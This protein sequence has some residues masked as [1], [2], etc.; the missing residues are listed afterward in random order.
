LRKEDSRAEDVE[1]HMSYVRW[2]SFDT[3]DDEDNDEDEE[4]KRPLKRFRAPKS[5]S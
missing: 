5:L 4:G 1:F 2:W 3:E